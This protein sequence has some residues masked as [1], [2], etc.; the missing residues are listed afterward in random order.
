MSGMHTKP[1]SH[2][3][4]AGKTRR[5]FPSLNQKECICVPGMGH[6]LVWGQPYALQC[7]LWEAPNQPSAPRLFNPRP[8]AM[9]LTMMD[10]PKV[11]GAHRDQGKA[12]A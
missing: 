1:V 11:S 7:T 5:R 12:D 3:G 9:T 8:Y 10:K 6:R 2:H 4:K